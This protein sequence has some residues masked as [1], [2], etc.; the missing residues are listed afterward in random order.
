MSIFDDPD[1]A[2]AFGTIYQVG[3]AEFEKTASESSWAQR[4]RRMVSRGTMMLPADWEQ[5]AG[6]DLPVSVASALRQA[7]HDGASDFA[8]VGRRHGLRL[9][10]PAADPVTEAR[11][12]SVLRRASQVDS[13]IFADRGLSG[14]ILWGWPLEVRT[15]GGGPA[16]AIGNYYHKELLV[17]EPEIKSA[18][19]THLLIIESPDEP[20]PVI[21]GRIDAG[22]VLVFVN[23]RDDVTLE[24]LRTL[25]KVVRFRAAAAVKRPG[26]VAAFI[27]HFLDELAHNNPPDVAV[28]HTAEQSGDYVILGDPLFLNQARVSTF[29][30]RLEAEVERQYQSGV[31]K[32][33][34]FKNALRATKTA[35]SPLGWRW[36][37]EG[38]AATETLSATE[39]AREVMRSPAARSSLLAEGA[40]RYLQAQVIEQTGKG[41]VQRRK[42]FEADADHEIHVRIG[43]S[44]LDWI[45]VRRR[46]PDHELPN[47]EA[48]LTVHLLMPG[49]N[50][51]TGVQEILI[52]STGASRVAKFPVHIPA[53]MDRID[54][55]IT[56]YH[57]GKHLQ[58]AVLSGPVTRGEETTDATGIK[59]ARGIPSSVDF[60]HQQQGDLI[61]EKESGELKLTVFNPNAEPEQPSHEVLHPSL[62]GV[63]SV[64]DQIRDDLFMTASKLEQLGSDIETSGL[65]TIR[66][67]AEQGEFLRRKL[68]GD[69][70]PEHL[71]RV[72][73]I[74]PNSSDLILPVEFLYDY[75]LPDA[76]AAL[77]PEFRR[78]KGP[79]CSDNCVAARGDTRYVCPSGFWALNRI[80]ERQVRPLDR[81]DSRQPESSARKPD[82][83]SFKGIIFAASDEV[84]EDNP[85]EVSETIATMQ[86]RTTVHYA[87]TWQEWADLIAKHSPSLLVVLPHN[88]ESSPFH[89]L[90]ISASEYLAL[91]RIKA[92][93][94]A[95]IERKGGQAVLLLGCNTANAAVEY[96]DFINEIRCAG[97]ALVIGTL[98][99]V[100][101]QQAARVAREFVAQ[102]WSARV[103][104]TVGEIMRQVRGQMLAE[105]NLMA[106][107]ITAFGDADWRFQ[108]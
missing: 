103:S 7:W 56:V 44:S 28:S 39:P 20:M 29:T 5:A 46:F 80:I 99:Y 67:L 74:S 14:P 25:N 45:S 47:D 38:K 93:H 78:S 58:T 68:F 21:T 50:P 33:N 73:V 15:I 35:P 102:I 48:R 72:Q 90:Q 66:G 76:D 53:N 88:V 16:A 94:F 42:S 59:F 61:V 83:M 1:V 71:Q 18:D 55:T 6:T 9:Q 64:V 81:A 30:A 85:N 57:E 77:C 11:I 105:D 12:T 8:K 17:L 40:E 26:D 43:P 52:G 19:S 54:A 22:F 41:P 36:H 87:S 70:P 79:D 23:S 32:F 108:P 27:N 24:T 34:T 92:S 62:A 37:S 63:N 49:A 31:L 104:A 100:L 2:A 89:R 13:I 107:A 10:I 86:K 95:P 75:A 82:L 106:L 101:G 97:A 51:E 65:P 69:Q 3:A 98:T 91:N 4:V 84:N 60:D 96:Q